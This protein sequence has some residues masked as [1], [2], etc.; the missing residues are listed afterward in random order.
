M[1][2]EFLIYAFTSFVVGWIIWFGCSVVINK[3]FF[4]MYV[5]KKLLPIWIVTIL[6]IISTVVAFKYEF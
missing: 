4:Q 3:I 1:T 6:A 2:F 5:S